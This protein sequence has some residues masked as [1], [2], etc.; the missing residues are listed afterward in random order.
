MHQQVRECVEVSGSLRELA[1]KD[2][3][4]QADRRASV[5]KNWLENEKNRLSWIAF[6]RNVLIFVEVSLM[7]RWIEPNT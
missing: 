2:A 5:R 1:Q 4:V 3:A 6:K 7:D